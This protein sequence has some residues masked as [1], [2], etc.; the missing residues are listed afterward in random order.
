MIIETLCS[1]Y[2]KTSYQKTFICKYLILQSLNEMYPVYLKVL[3]D[4]AQGC[5]WGRQSNSHEYILR[6]ILRLRITFHF[7]IYE[8]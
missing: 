1:R 2:D 5:R 8:Y 7:A 6:L 3:T 4:C